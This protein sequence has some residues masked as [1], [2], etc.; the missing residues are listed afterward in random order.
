MKFF[1]RTYGCQM[2]VRDSESVESILMDSGLEKADDDGSADIFIV[3]TCSV[4][5]K[6]EDKAIGKLGVMAKAKRDGSG[7]ILGVMGCMVQR[8]QEQVFK[9]VPD[10]DFAV[11]THRFSRMPAVIEAVKVGAGPVLEAGDDNLIEELSGHTRVGMSAFINI[12]FGCDRR[13]SFC[14]VPAVRG[15][16]RSRMGADVLEEV[17]AVA[18]SG[19]REVTLLGQS[20]MSYGRKGCVWPDDYNSANGYTEPLPRLLEAVCAVDGIKR[21]RFT[22]GHPSGC[23][24]ELAR[25]MAELPEVCEHMHLPLQSASD[26]ILGSMRRGYKVED[27]RAAVQCLREAVPDIAVSTDII[28]GFPS[29][30]EEDFEM[31]RKFM[32]DIG[33]DNAFIFKYSPR[34]S[35]PAEKMGD[36]VSAEEKMRRNKVLLEEQDKR[37][38]AVNEGMVGRSFKVLAE[39]VSLRNAERWSGRTGSNRIVVFEPQDG[40]NKGDIVNVRIERAMAQ[41]VYGVIE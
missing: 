8:M 24:A 3:N 6:A 36:D 21:V 41:T 39:G 5:G 37:S 16:E 32:D 27:Y 15:E 2:N 33:F 17:K 28:V 40:L 7:Q 9:K 22:S 19:V 4:R 20:V 38:K 34:P 31:T 23:T 18:E 35:T 29:E 25:A 26:R 13:C 10:L 14:I 30:T 12:L 11:G 1:I